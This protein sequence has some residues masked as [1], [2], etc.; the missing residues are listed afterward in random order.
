MFVIFKGKGGR[1]TRLSGSR[2]GGWG[3]GLCQICGFKHAILERL[4]TPCKSCGSPKCRC[5]SKW[6]KRVNVWVDA[7]FS[8]AG[9]FYPSHPVTFWMS[10]PPPLFQIFQQCATHLTCKIS[11][12]SGM[13]ADMVKRMNINFTT[14][15][16]SGML[17]STFH[18]WLVKVIRFLYGNLTA[19]EVLLVIPARNTTDVPVWLWFKMTI[20]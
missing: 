18:H 14:R 6:E 1:H 7:T 16:V 8:G 13:G 9:Q 2:G 10:F 15:R 11:P 20:S 5:V 17:L 4:V 19:C 3:P 12:V